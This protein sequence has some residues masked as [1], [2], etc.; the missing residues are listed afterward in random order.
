MKTKKLNSKSVRSIIKKENRKS[1]DLER[2]IKNFAK[3]YPDNITVI[4][5]SGDKGSKDIAEIVKQ[6]APNTKYIEGPVS[7]ITTEEVSDI[8]LD[9]SSKFRENYKANFN[10]AYQQ[11]ERYLLEVILTIHKCVAFLMRR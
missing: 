5:P 11:L 3:A 1:I 8:V 2:E 6:Y 10:E 4:V 9:G 7:G